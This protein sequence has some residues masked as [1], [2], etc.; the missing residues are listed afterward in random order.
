MNMSDMQRPLWLVTGAAGALGRELVAGIME[1]GADC[2]ALDRDEAGLNALHDER[3]EAGRPT[4][5]LMPMDL[6]G[7]T[8]ADFQKLAETIE[9]TFGRL[10]VIIHNAMV[11]KSLRPLFHQSP[12]EWIDCIQTGL[13]GPF[14][15]SAALMPLLSAAPAGTLVFINDTAALERPAHRAA[16]GVA[17][18]GRRQMV[19]TLEAERGERGVQVVE[20][21]PGSFYSP[22][23]AAARPSDPPGSLR[24]AGEAARGVLREIG[25]AAPQMRIG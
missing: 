19:R 20:I 3:S 18:A 22:L 12:E 14:L 17:G 6:A 10:D 11:F 13:T 1:G 24:S 2:I 21:D 4:P 16:Y 25:R 9:Q 8:P 7:A 23:H 5:A 15:L